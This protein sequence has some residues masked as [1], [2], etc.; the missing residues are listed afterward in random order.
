MREF[1]GERP[2]R[3]TAVVAA[4]ALISAAACTPGEAAQSAQRNASMFRGDPAHTGVYA[5]TAGTALG[6]LKWRFMT[7]GDVISSPVVLGQTVYVGSGDGHLYALDRNTGARRWASD[8]GNPIPSSP[9]V[10][11]GAVYVGTRDGHFVAVDASTGR[12]RWR[13]TTGQLMPWPWGHESG[14]VYTSSPTFVDGTVFFGAGDGRVYAVDA[15]T[16]KEKWRAA[17]TGRVRSS[18][19]VDA[20]RVY[21]GSAD[22]RVYAFDRATG[23][24]RWKFDTEGVKLE[25]KNF[26]YDRR[27]VQSSPAV[28]NGTVFIG[29][30][31]GWLYALDA[32]TGAE[33]W[34]FDHKISWVNTSPAVLDGV[35]YAGSSDGQF[36]QAVDAASGKELW[37]TTT[38]TTW[39]S[40]AVAGDVIYAG[41]GQG[42]LHALERKTGKLLWSFRTGSSVHSS[43]TPAGDLV[44]VGSTDGG[45]YA[46][47]TASTPVRRAVFFDST[48]IKSAWVQDAATMSRY[49][50]NRGYELLDEAALGTFLRA[51]I[52]DRA[53][54]VLVFALDHLPPS[55]LDSTA[56]ERSAFRRYL[57]AGGKVVWPGVPPLLFVKDPKTGSPGGLAALKW[58]N[59][60]A[61]L[62]VPHE[63]AMFDVRG[64]RATDA[65]KQWG[66]PNRWRVG[67]GI[68]PDRSITVLGRDEFGLATAW[69]R[70]YGGPEG[71]G[72]VR[73][74]DDPMVAYLAAEYRP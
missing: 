60:S 72:F 65:G 8:V 45:V 34:R 53:P 32:A 62:G 26:G 31:D 35:V 74:P 11:A 5:A 3:R 29:A 70:R 13:F 43:P 1:I 66:L 10:G 14:D 20:S 64:T 22:G 46:L 4:V 12:Q 24:A 42:R 71:T 41:D 2:N 68:D 21:V 47:R 33:R 17:T 6:G 63:A 44:I 61:L 55:V 39:S 37:R 9:A 56:L 30:R 69:V 40:P 50:V 19:A 23:A 54:S 51:R 52:E 57:D 16:G 36:V 38:G 27:T 28:V 7:E 58:G 73:V 48:Y 25:S 49:F 59:S 18:P 15:T 67:W